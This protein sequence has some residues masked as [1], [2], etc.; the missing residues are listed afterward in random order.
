MAFYSSFKIIANILNVV[1]V[2]IHLLNVQAQYIIT[3]TV[4]YHKDI[5]F[6]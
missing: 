2:M 6:L 5:L 1:A 3:H 4:S